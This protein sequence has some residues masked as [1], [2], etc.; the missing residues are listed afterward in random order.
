MGQLLSGMGD[1][2]LQPVEAEELG[3]RMTTTFLPGP[4]WLQSLKASKFGGLFLL[5]SNERRWKE[6][7]LRQS[8]GL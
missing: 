2:V 6:K 4:T 7:R 3:E 5:D 1:T 8:H